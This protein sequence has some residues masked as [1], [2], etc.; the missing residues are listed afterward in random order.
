[1]RFFFLAI[2]L[3]FSSRAANS[4]PVNFGHDSTLSEPDDFSLVDDGN[5]VDNGK[6]MELAALDSSQSFQFD[7]FS[8]QEA[9]IILPDLQIIP[10][11]A[12]ANDASPTNLLADL[13]AAACSDSDSRVKGSAQNN[14]GNLCPAK[15]E[16][17]PSRPRQST[18]EDRQQK[19]DA[20]INSNPDEKKEDGPIMNPTP[21]DDICT[22][23]KKLFCCF[24]REIENWNSREGCEEC[25]LPFLHFIQDRQPAHEI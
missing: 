6:V 20:G 17:P 5:T 4:G 14:N 18:E 21:P 13:P 1:M 10:G 22:P 8:N 23:P 19:K 12:N 2:L 15:L 25:M 24:G 11:I 9:N 3:L 16:T 7:A